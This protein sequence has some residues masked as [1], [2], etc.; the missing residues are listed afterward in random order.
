MVGERIRA[1]GA[2]REIHA[3][4]LLM[5]PTATLAAD[6]QVQP[7][8]FAG[9]RA[10]GGLITTSLPILSP[11]PG[12]CGKPPGPASRGDGRHEQRQGQLGA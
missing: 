11:A 4:V 12:V 9:G 6:P 10:G 8:G 2:V 5:G 7:W 1:G 3:G